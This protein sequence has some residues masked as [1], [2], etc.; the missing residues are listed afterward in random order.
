MPPFTAIDDEF[1]S[2]ITDTDCYCP[3]VG[4]VRPTA[5]SNT[6]LIGVL[7]VFI[8]LLLIVIVA[9]VVVGVL[10]FLCYKRMKMYSTKETA[11]DGGGRFSE[12]PDLTKTPNSYSCHSPESPH[13]HSRK[14]SIS[15]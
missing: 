6:A 5:S 14:G 15:R 9:L 12:E 4:G 10:I 13:L 1:P 11:D 7:A 3:D 2:T 8:V